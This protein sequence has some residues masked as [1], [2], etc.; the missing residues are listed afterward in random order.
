[1]SSTIAVNSS[2]SNTIPIPKIAQDTMLGIR[3]PPQHV[4][5]H[6]QNIR[7][8]SRKTS[9]DYNITTIHEEK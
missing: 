8:H 7:T 4:F 6:T 3:S 9:K 1:M 2:I 5:L